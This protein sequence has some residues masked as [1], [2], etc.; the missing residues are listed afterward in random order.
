M[1]KT[2][3]PLVEPTKLLERISVDNL[4]FINAL[5]HNYTG[6]A[7]LISPSVSGNYNFAE[8]ESDK[9]AAAPPSTNIRNELYY[10]LY[11]KNDELSICQLCFW[12]D[13]RISEIWTTI[14][15]IDPNG[16]VIWSGE[17]NKTT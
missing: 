6:G 11:D 14:E 17:T 1:Y 10:S 16:S 3:L 15:L 4:R 13:G 2:R 5:E 7:F 8:W 12:S 9:G